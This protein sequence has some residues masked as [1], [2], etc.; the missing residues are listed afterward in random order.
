MTSR[1]R[2]AT[3]AAVLMIGAA[4]ALA[5]VAF[6]VS[7]SDDQP[8]ARGTTLAETTTTGGATTTDS[9]PAPPY[10]LG[11]T[12][13]CLRSAGFT[14]SAIRSDD[15]RLRALGDL[16]QRTS[17]ELTRDGH[18]LG[19]A[20]GD[21][22]LLESL[23]RVPNDLYRLEVRRNALLMYRPGALADAVVVRRCLRP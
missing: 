4:I 12:R 3:G 8:A 10:A 19:L 5:V 20:F 18:T 17:L 7:D 11:P 13:R 1:A 23:L 6:G 2:Y 22:R 9:A 14:V 15:P 21:T 16:A